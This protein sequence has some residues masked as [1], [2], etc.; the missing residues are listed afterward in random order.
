MRKVLEHALMW[1]GDPTTMPESD[2]LEVLDDY[3]SYL[4]DKADDERL[5]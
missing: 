4:E 2:P 1:D 5:N 3:E